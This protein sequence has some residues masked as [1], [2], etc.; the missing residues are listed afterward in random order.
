MSEPLI[1]PQWE[2]SRLDTAYHID[3][4]S[5]T[6]ASRQFLVSCSRLLNVN[7]WHVLCGAL[8]SR[9]EV[10]STSGVPVDRLAREG[11]YFRINIPAPG[12]LEGDGYDWVRIE[13]IEH[14]NDLVTDEDRVSM[15]V[16]PAPNP[17]GEKSDIAHFFAQEAT[18]TFRVRRTQLKV[19]ASVHGRN[20]MANDATATPADNVRNTLVSIGARAG[21]SALQWKSLVR[22]I[23]EGPPA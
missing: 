18:S 9:F 16:R 6:Q 14:H 19:T 13:R 21:M 11:D 17:T 7:E 4:G 23:I 15:R 2:G 8:S 5:H 10:V 1:P 12:P 20:E 22:G 3:C